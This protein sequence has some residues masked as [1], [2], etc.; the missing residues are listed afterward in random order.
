M[1]F[2][3]EIYKPDLKKIFLKDIIETEKKSHCPACE[4]KNEDDLIS[5]KFKKTQISLTVCNNCGH[6]YY[7]EFLTKKFIDN[8]YKEDFSSSKLQSQKFIDNIHLHKGNSN[9]L[10]L[11]IDK[12]LDN[13]NDMKILE[14]GCGDGAC[15]SYLRVNGFKHLFGNEM[16]KARA[17]NAK[18]IKN[19]NIFDGGYE[20]I[21][22]QKFD[23]IYSNHV[24]EHILDLNG[25]FDKLS[26]ISHNKT[27]II[28][29]LPDQRFENVFNKIFFIGHIHSFNHKSI[30]YLSKKF[31]F[32]VKFLK[33]IRPD[34]ICLIVSKNK[35]MLNN[36]D[37][38]ETIKFK[39]PKEIKNCILKPFI[40]SKKKFMY[41]TVDRGVRY[42]YFD[43]KRRLDTFIKITP[44]FSRIMY[45]TLILY[46]FGRFLKNNFLQ[47]LADFIIKILSN[48]KILHQGYIK[49]KLKDSSHKNQIILKNESTYLDYK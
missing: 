6:I 44:F 36:F 42:N 46:N 28:F 47:R 21:P 35:E 49:L 29:N 11:I 10:Y 3:Y 27:L 5:I 43:Y 18:M 22:N 8:Y 24:I 20:N 33:P 25:F 30:F 7:R 38:E 34:E 26:K 15:L 13:L 19:V 31:N 9:K 32:N 14:I 37:S 12:K 39:Q 48:K 45:F 41:Y 2:D 17:K 23:I 4:E 40:E 16:N 1:I